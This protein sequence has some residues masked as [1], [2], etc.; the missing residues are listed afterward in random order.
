MVSEGTQEQW[1][2]KPRPSYTPV[3]PALGSRTLAQSSSGG[4]AG[5]GSSSVS[6]SPCDTPAPGA[7]GSCQGSVKAVYTVD[8]HGNLKSSH[9]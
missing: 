5:Q 6:L 7:P 1:D 3:S 9:I 2:A 8:Q 4:Q